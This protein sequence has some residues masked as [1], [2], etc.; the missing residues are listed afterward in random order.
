MRILIAMGMLIVFISAFFIILTGETMFRNAFS[1]VDD[2]EKQ[3]CVYKG[4][5]GPAAFG[6]FIIA[7]F[8]MIDILTVYLIITNMS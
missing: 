2:G 3:V 7:F 1:C 4:L 6:V 8:I 5:P